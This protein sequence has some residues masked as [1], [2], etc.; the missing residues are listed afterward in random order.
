M[1]LEDKYATKDSVSP[2]LDAF[3]STALNDGELVVNNSITL[4]G[5]GHGIY[6]SFGDSGFGFDD[7]GFP[8]ILNAKTREIS[9]A[10]DSFDGDYL[11]YK[12]PENSGTIALT[13][14]LSSLAS[15]TYV[16]DSVPTLT[17]GT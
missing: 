1:K 15:K 16:D 17:F 3:D 14:D 8:C 2:L 13:S 7:E 9:V 5:T 10:V 6:E 4:N 12:F 11:R